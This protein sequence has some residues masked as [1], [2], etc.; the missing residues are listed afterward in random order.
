MTASGLP[1]RMLPRTLPASPLLRFLVVGG[2]ALSACADP[3]PA[4]APDE[5]SPAQA[6]PAGNFRGLIYERSFVFTADTDT[7]FVVPML[8][9]SRTKPGGVDREARGWLRRGT[10]WEAFHDARWETPPTRAPWRLLPHQGLRLMVGEQDALETI[11][12]EEGVRALELEFGDVL[13]EWTTGGGEVFRLL[14]AAVYLSDQRVPGVMLDASRTYGSD[15]TPPGDWAFLTSGDSLH[16]VFES[17]RRA[18]PETAGAYR[19]WARL[20]F[21]DLQWSPVTITWTETS[22]FQPARQDVPVS[23]RV[24]SPEVEGTLRVATAQIQAGEGPGPLLPVDALFGVEGTL[25]I[26]GRPYPVRGLFRHTRP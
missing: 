23:W 25:R 5:T 6:A 17:P 14:D 13:I 12:F 10:T 26:E 11:L 16:V 7:A 24:S 1:S 21:R 2:A 19:G 3:E 9:V 4:P 15:Q 8:F 20:D 18:A 22:A